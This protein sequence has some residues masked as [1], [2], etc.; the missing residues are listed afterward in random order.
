MSNYAR[1]GRRL[2]VGCI[3]GLALS[4]IATLVSPFEGFV[5]RVE[6]ATAVG[7]NSFLLDDPIWDWTIFL[8]SSRTWLLVAFAVGTAGGLVAARRNFSRDYGRLIGF[9]ALTALLAVATDELADTI[10]EVIRRSPPLHADLGLSDLVHIQNPDLRIPYETGL[11]AEDVACLA[12]LAFLLFA[13]LPRLGL[14]ILAIA[15]LHCVGQLSIGHRWLMDMITAIFFG[16]AV[17]GG[18]LWW[19]RS[20]FAWAEREAERLLLSDLWWLVPGGRAFSSDLARLRRGPGRPAA[21]PGGG[22]GMLSLDERLWRRA[23]NTEVLP[24]FGVPPGEG[25]ILRKPPAATSE[26]WKSSRY[27]RFAELPS[28]QILVVK[29]AWRFGGIWHRSRR[30]RRYAESARSALTLEKLGQP[31]PRVYWGAEGVSHLGFV[32]Y[33][34]LVEEF[35]EGRPLDAE[36]GKEAAAAMRALAGLHRNEGKSWGAVAGQSGGKGTHPAWIWLRL[37]PDIAGWLRR[38]AADRD[39]LWPDG[40]EQGIWSRIERVAIGLMD[41]PSPPAFRL[42]HGDVGI[43]NFMWSGEGVR[44]ID[45]VTAQYD[46]AGTE[47]IRAARNFGGRDPERSLAVWRAYF[48]EAGEERWREF[49]ITANLSLARYALREFAQD[50]VPEFKEESV[51]DLAGRLPGWVDGILDL[52]PG[53]WGDSPAQTDWGALLAI[54]RGSTRLARS[55]ENA[56]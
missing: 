30:V 41:R 8:F 44:L 11:P 47:I 51:A 4:Y 53:V 43:R 14:T 9:L 26:H 55:G 40:V 18:T 5:S 52:D 24:L 19:G 42:I 34:L 28:G 29:F 38:A 48:D 50:R 31:V 25:R 10:S 3:L 33:F 37:R 20:L 45:F 17:A 23:I 35:I 22:G 6:V 1:Y 46:L 7:L 15:A 56:A 32:R 21:P 27:V 36:S 54:L 49:L 16:G 2:A 13:R 39:D 12:C